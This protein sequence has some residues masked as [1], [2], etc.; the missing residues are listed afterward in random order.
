MGYKLGG[1]RPFF[2]TKNRTKRSQSK[3]FG[4]ASLQSGEACLSVRLLIY[5]SDQ[6]AS[7]GKAGASTKTNK[8]A[9][10]EASLTALQRG[11]A[12]VQFSKSA[13][14]PR[15]KRPGSQR[16]AQIDTPANTKV[17][18]TLNFPLLV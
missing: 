8:E 15:A 1:S 17:R 2:D 12:G 9:N 13:S 4:L 5:S 11:K 16:L 18:D 14:N 10:G 7:P 6:P 3:H